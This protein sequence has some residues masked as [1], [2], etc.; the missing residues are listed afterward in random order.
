MHAEILEV[1]LGYHDAQGVGDAAYAELDGG[2]VAE[3]GYDVGGDGLVNL[4]G[5]AA[6]QLDGRA[7]LAL[8]H[9]VNLGDMHALLLAAHGVRQALEDLDYDDIRVVYVDA[10]V[11]GGDG[12][13]EV[14]V[15]VH[16]RRADEGD[17]DVQ[18]VVV[19]PAQVAV[20]HGLVIAQPAVSQL[21]VVAGEMPAVVGEMLLLRVA[22]D[23]GHG[24]VAEHTADLYVCELVAPG[25]PAPRRRASGKRRRYRIPPS[26]R[27]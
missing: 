13:V 15:L 9:H 23:G 16:G 26:P 14:T 22:L 8:D 21:A 17:V 1:A 25:A 10:R 27:S 12:E 18:E 7:V 2:A 6:G 3:V 4:G 24:A 5:L 11:A 20:E 19:E